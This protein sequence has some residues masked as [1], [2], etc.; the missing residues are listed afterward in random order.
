MTLT[1]LKPEIKQA[2]LF[3]C[4]LADAILKDDM[5]T[6]EHPVFTLSKKPDI[7]ERYYEHNGNRLWV[8]P[9][10]KGLATIYDKDILIYA[11][12]KLMKKKN[13]GEPIN[14]SIVFE[15]QECLRFICR[16]GKNGN[17]G[18]AD[19]RR[20]E[21]ALERLKGT[22]LKTDIRTNG[23]AQTKIFGLIDDAIIHRED[24][25]GKVLEWGITL[26]DW[27]YNSILGDEVLTL[28]KDYFRLRTP[29]EKRI[30]ELARRHC[31]K[32]DEWSIKLELLLKKTG[33]E[34]VLRNFRGIIRKIAQSDHLPDYSI[35]ID[36]NDN[37][38]FSKRGDSNVGDYSQTQF[39]LSFH[40][41]VDSLDRY[42]DGKAQK[43]CPELARKKG[44]DYYYLKSEFC[45]FI[46]KKK[47][48]PEN[49]SASFIAFIK[50]KKIV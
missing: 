34:M 29:T 45:D 17:P 24:F 7:K 44:I 11:I 30:Y 8:T 1:P 49:I 18:G 10:V 3:V 31:G 4:D 2:D 25:D 16:T 6:M 21:S 46:N 27:V 47:E 43:S 41:T 13:A 48:A 35:M 28:H 23:I 50:Q 37:V 14:K 5:A 39:N 33:S 15:A 42:L 36:K 20:L 22:M 19:Y 12:S 40:L 32:Q 9:S 38:I 26:S